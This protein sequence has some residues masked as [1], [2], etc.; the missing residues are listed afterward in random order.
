MKSMTKGDPMSSNR[1]MRFRLGA[2]FITI[3]A[4]MS[5]ALYADY[6]AKNE[7]AKD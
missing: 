3:A 1:M 4:L 6:K 5:V 2:Q 7:E